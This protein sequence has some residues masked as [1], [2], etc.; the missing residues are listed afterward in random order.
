MSNRLKLTVGVGL[1]M[2]GIAWGTVGQ[3]SDYLVGNRTIF[4]AAPAC[5]DADACTELR[6]LFIV[7]A[8]S[9]TLM[10]RNPFE[11]SRDGHIDAGRLAEGGVDLQVFAVASVAP[12]IL[13]RDDGPCGDID[14]G[15]RLKTYFLL[16]E[17]LNPS[18]WTSAMA[19]VDHMVALFEEG[20]GETSEG[21][22]V[23]RIR[24][25]SDLETLRDASAGE[26]LLGALLSIEGAYWASENQEALLAQMDGLDAAGVRMIGLTHRS[27]NQLAGFNEDCDDKHGL[28]EIGEFLVRDI[29]RRGMILDLAHASSKTLADVAALSKSG[30]GGQVIVSHTGVRRACPIDRNLTDEDVRNVARMGGVISLGFWTTV[31]CFDGSVSANEAR[32]AIAKSFAITLE[33]LSEPEFVTEMGTSYEPMRHIGLGSDFDGATLVPSGAE[34]IPWYLEGISGFQKNGLQPFDRE[35]IENIA[36]ENLFRLLTDSLNERRNRERD[37]FRWNIGACGNGAFSE[38]ATH[39]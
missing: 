36:G 17:P 5:D 9:D 30:A 29:W 31:N 18:T 21:R 4:S 12:K 1:A 35:A 39:P 16:K 3:F 32:E 25:L 14:E 37:P 34:A 19:R 15:D 24:T 22:S 10:H 38:N 28:T 23:Q 33:I 7:D 20:L 2:L 8:H 27:S 13:Q 6:D 26:N 11:H